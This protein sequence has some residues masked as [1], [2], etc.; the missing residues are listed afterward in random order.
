MR[1]Q[2]LVARRIQRRNGL[3]KQDKTA[4]KFPDLLD[5]GWEVS[6]KTV[7]DSMRRQGWS[8][9]GSGAGTG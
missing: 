3:T 6:E 4:A 5:D 2:G 1:R 8:H 7:A 9:A